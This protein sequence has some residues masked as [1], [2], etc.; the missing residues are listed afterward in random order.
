MG[1]INELKVKLA[2][3]GLARMM[4]VPVEKLSSNV[5]TLWYRAPELLLGESQYDYKID[6]WSVGCIFYYLITKEVLF[7]SNSEEE[8]L[9]EIGMKM[10][11]P[12]NQ[13]YIDKFKE[14]EIIIEKENIF[15][16]LSNDIDKEGL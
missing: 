11:R 7:S 3:F 2:D 1:V 16:Q 4:S 9:E 13:S 8:M 15:D 6:V 5:V 10:K 12:K 14:K